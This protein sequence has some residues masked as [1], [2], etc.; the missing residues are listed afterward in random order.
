P[1][2]YWDVLAQGEHGGAV[3]VQS[4]RAGVSLTLTIGASPEG[5]V[6]AR[7]IYRTK[8]GGSEYF[9]VGELQSNVPVLFTDYAFDQNLMTRNLPGNG[10][11]GRQAWLRAIPFGLT[12]T[13]GRRL[14]RSRA[15][16]PNYFM[17]LVVKEKN[18]T[19]WIANAT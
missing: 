8:A 6:L 3:P 7:R 16:S 11:A 5:G 14:Y 17:I 4:L 15:N 9:L 18:S 13:T 10:M 12:G 1:L 19:T 2:A